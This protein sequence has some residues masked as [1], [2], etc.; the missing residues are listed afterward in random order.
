[1]R[2]VNWKGGEG[3]EEGRG[4]GRERGEELR[5]GWLIGRKGKGGEMED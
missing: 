2:V 1:M 3:G 5:R 4:K